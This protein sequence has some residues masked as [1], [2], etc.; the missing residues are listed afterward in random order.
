MKI[1]RVG[2]F[3]RDRLLDYPSKES[4]WVVVGGTPEQLLELGYEP[5]GKDFPVFLHPETHEEYALA[6]T[7]RKTSP[8]YHGFQFNTST[9]V[10][11]EEDLARRDLTINAM[12]E[13]EAG[14]LIDPLGGK[15]DLE[16][17]TLRHTSPAFS[18]D[19]VR[20]LRVARFA[21]RY[22]HLGF[23][24]AE[25]TLAL[26][27][28]MAN[29]GEA[30]HL[31]PERVWQETR[32]ALD[33]R[34]PEQ[35]FE[36]LRQCQTL[37]IIFPEINRLFGVPQP[38]KYHPEID[39]GV[40][41]L[42]SLQQAVKLNADTISRFATLVHDLGKADTPPE[43]WPSHIGHEEKSCTRIREMCSRLAIP[44]RFRDLALAVGRYHT[45]CH[46]AGNLKS[47]TL[48]KLLE[49][50]GALRQPET[51]E[52]FLVCCE[53]DARGRTG[54][55]QQPY[56]Q[57]NVV[58]AA[59]GACQTIKGSTLAEEGLTGKQLGDELRQRQIRAIEQTRR[60]Q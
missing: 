38:E 3:I 60:N 10:T 11:L 16:R 17:R 15:E 8:G 33:E 44:N 46:K 23:T 34:N 12:A 31:V 29:N 51:L 14:N 52:A 28:T 58:R 49:G 2:G 50:C 7:E 1:Y 18:E 27:S 4:D 5:V 45:L 6:R 26:M 40:H 42:M 13:D 37:E 25:E 22:H 9:E 54:L 59:L 32:R 19:P 57:A 20:I 24:I 21:A 30:D 43:E 55:E 56:P 47:K 39:C 35:F 41:S 36:I 48:H 53:A